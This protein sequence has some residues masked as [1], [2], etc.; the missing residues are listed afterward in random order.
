[1]KYLD[2]DGLTYLWGKIKS[3]IPTKYSQLTNDN[4]TVSDSNYVHTDNN[5][6]NSEKNKLSGIE[7][8]AQKNV[9]ETDPTVPSWA[10]ASTKPT[11]KYSEITEKPSTYTP[12][13]HTHNTSEITDL[14]VSISISDEDFENILNGEDV[15]VTLPTGANDAMSIDIIAPVGKF[16]LQRI[17]SAYDGFALAF[18][19]AATNDLFISLMYEGQNGLIT[20]TN[21]FTGSYNDLTDKPT[22]PTKTSQLTNDSGYIKSYTETDPT[23]P[24]WAKASTKPTY[25]YSEITE[26]PTLATVA[27]SGSYSDLSNK[28]TATTIG[29][30]AAND[31]KGNVTGHIYLTGAK[32]SSSTGSTSQIV[33]GTSSNNHVAISSN[34]NAIVLN[35]T[36][37][38]TTNQIVMYLDKKSQFPSGIDAGSLSEGGVEL[39]NKY[40]AKADVPTTTSQLTNNSNFIASTVVTAFWSGTQAEYDAI[41]TKNATTLYLITE[42]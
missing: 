2:K 37:D 25:K 31:I 5:Y 22:I 28:P 13:L 23:V 21:L 33:F 20:N 39:S 8:G 41:T 12:S 3:K 15:S 18:G 17:I 35:P 30:I 7:T 38:S 11:Y 6:T 10:K 16:T 40:A 24:A 9:A 26:K 32:P 36:T 42:E 19:G 27:T 14:S 34:N 1:M 4:N 29:A